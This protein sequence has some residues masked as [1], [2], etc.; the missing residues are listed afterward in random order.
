LIKL[1]SKKESY[2]EQKNSENLVKKT[3]KELGITQK[4]LAEK[5]GV[6]KTT[7]SDWSVGK[8][9]I[10][11]MAQNLL[12]LLTEQKEHLRFR[13]SIKELLNKSINIIDL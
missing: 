5:I 12:N 9:Q 2:L 1:K 8:T 3:C 11:K 4:E 6:S 10:P 13:E 7:I